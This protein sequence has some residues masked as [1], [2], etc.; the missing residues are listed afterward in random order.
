MTPLPMISDTAHTCDLCWEQIPVGVPFAH[1]V[2][3]DGC[4]NYRAHVACEEVF[5]VIGDPGARLLSRPETFRPRLAALSQSDLCE[6]LQAHSA[7]EIVRMVNLRQR[8]AETTP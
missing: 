5:G 6:I 8:L 1:A 3:L 2:I 4:G 7:D